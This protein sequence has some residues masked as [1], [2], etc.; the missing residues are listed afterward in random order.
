MHP[1]FM[2]PSTEA[3]EVEHVH[4]TLKEKNIA[5]DLINHGYLIKRTCRNVESI[6]EQSFYE[7]NL[8]PEGF[9]TLQ[10]SQGC[11]YELSQ[12][13]GTNVYLGQTNDMILVRGKFHL[14]CSLWE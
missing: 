8:P 11:K 12:I 4:I 3:N 9:S 10:S 2:L 13:P 6:R 7:I 14:I 1:D 5:I